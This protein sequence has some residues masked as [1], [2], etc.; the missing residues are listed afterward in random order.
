VAN[1]SKAQIAGTK[2]QT[3]ANRSS[4]DSLILPPQLA[5]K[6]IDHAREG[7]PAEVC[8]LVAGRDGTAVAVHAGRNISPTPTVA[9]ELDDVTLARMIAFQDDGL[10]L[11]AI[12]HSHP[13][14]PAEPSP[15]DIRLAFYPESL[16]IIWSL[17]DQGEPV[18][19]GFRIAQGQ[20][21]EVSLVPGSC[22]D[23]LLDG[24]IAA[25]G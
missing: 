19:R 7:F 18:L 6:I 25:G 15:T 2:N 1:R 5:A 9:Y 3:G 22:S 17:T 11:V 4:P 23:S 12:Y 16:Y 21:V 14:G 20:V 10:E 24:D 8:G 13:H